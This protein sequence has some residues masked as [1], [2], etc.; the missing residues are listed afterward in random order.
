MTDDKPHLILE[1]HFNSDTQ[2]L[3]CEL[4]GVTYIA[5]EGGN[6][7]Y[8]KIFEGS[9]TEI[10]HDDWPYEKAWISEHLGHLYGY[11][12]PDQFPVCPVTGDRRQEGLGPNEEYLDHLQR[13]EQQLFGHQMAEILDPM[14]HEL[15]DSNNGLPIPLFVTPDMGLTVYK[16][17]PTNDTYYNNNY[18]RDAKDGVWNQVP[19]PC[20]MQPRSKGYLL[21]SYE[22]MLLAGLSREIVS[23]CEAG[24]WAK[25][26][27][28]EF[29]KNFSLPTVN[30]H[31]LTKDNVHDIY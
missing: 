2:E 20:A 4:D 18:N 23:Q 22:E 3:M 10:S 14:E 19:Q 9:R 16:L 21:S 28:P 31:P 6:E 26:A 11:Y 8:T 27:A 29:L 5:H 25:P 12:Q 15:H 13:V 24:E 7:G 1:W 17:L 30:T